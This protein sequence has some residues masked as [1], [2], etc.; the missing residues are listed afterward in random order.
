MMCGG[1][2]RGRSLTESIFV[3]GSNL[4]GRH[5]AGA[6]KHARDH[7]GAVYGQGSGRQG[8]SYAIPTKDGRNGAS[9]RDSAQTLSLDVIATEVSTFLVYAA[10]H[11]SDQFK[12]AAIG[13]G[14]AGYMPAQIAPMFHGATDNVLLPLEFQGIASVRIAV[15]GGRNYSNKPRVWQVLDAAIIR[16]GMTSGVDGGAPGW[17]LFSRQWAESRGIPWKTVKAEWHKYGPAAGPIRNGRI[18][19]EE[20][21]NIV[22]AGPGNDGTQNMIDQTNEAIR[23]G[24]KIRLIEIDR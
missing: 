2:L 5:G 12:V 6:A 20:R 10:A 16:L 21:P 4:A 14:L 8:N 23:S 7:Y 24:E 1:L 11:P 18:L 22:I 9:L 17:D 15:T 3:F 13:C 19:R